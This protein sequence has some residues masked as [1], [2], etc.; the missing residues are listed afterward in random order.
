MIRFFAIGL[1]AML[2]A[3][4]AASA[5]VTFTTGPTG[6][7]SLAVNGF[8]TIGNP[9]YQGTLCLYGCDVTLRR[10]DGSTTSPDG[11]PIGATWTT[12][13]TLVLSFPYATLTARYARAPGSGM[14]VALTVR[15]TGADT[16][17]AFGGTLF[18]LDMPV[19]PTGT[20]DYGAAPLA[21]YPRVLDPARG[22]PA[23]QVGF[24]SYGSLLFSLASDAGQA[25]AQGATLGRLIHFNSDQRYSFRF[26]FAAPVPPGG[27][28]TQTL[29]IT[30]TASAR[31]FAVQ[32]AQTARAYAGALPQNVGAWR[33]R[34]PLP[35]WFLTGPTP[36]CANGLNPRG[37]F[38]NDCTVDI[39]TPGGLA[40]FRARMLGWT[41]E[42]IGNLRWMNAQGVVIWD[43]EG[44]QE[45]QA[46]SYVCDPSQL[47]TVA[48]EMNTRGSGDA[49]GLADEMVKEIEDAGFAVGFCLRPQAYTKTADGYAQLDQ[50]DP[51]A[52][53]AA[54][55]DYARR[56]WNARIFYVDSNVHPE[57]GWP[58]PAAVDF[59]PALAQHPDT[60]FIPEWMDPRHY[61]ITAPY[62][63]TLRPGATASD[64]KPRAEYPGSFGIVLPD[65]ATAQ[66]LRPKLLAAA[67]QGD[68]LMPPAWY[69][70]PE[71]VVTQ[72]IMAEI[73]R[74]PEIALPAPA[75]ARAGASVMLTPV[76]TAGDAAVTR[77]EFYA[78]GTKLGV[79]SAAPWSL[80]WRPTVARTES[81][82]A[83]VIDAA[84]NSAVSA[85]AAL[86]V[87]Q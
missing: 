64:P 37:W 16:I 23:L 2:G 65:Y 74:R 55:A 27:T 33:D 20:N 80:T 53:I 69:R 86:A 60:L 45:P 76:V 77:V 75:G 52:L 8:E 38:N 14:T 35:R 42:V 56:R 44:Q 24:G 15:N 58:I 26:D 46:T 54:K 78:G 83:K 28:A 85:P 6:L 31:P 7:A 50:N 51:G 49:R 4:G 30:A 71:A 67:R 19:V 1:L 10:S 36:H 79:S 47:D 25:V 40:D 22:V 62:P 57:L 39:T 18:V 81:L 72:S 29:G 32:A 66:R 41:Q 13:G 11:S 3:P 21:D 63:G 73:G 9:D 48:P 68:I 5:A 82:V 43:I 34:R 17:A 59:G 70:A 61:G 84:G 12:P 87:T